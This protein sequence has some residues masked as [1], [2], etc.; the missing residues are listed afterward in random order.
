MWNLWK[1]PRG[2]F[3]IYRGWASGVLRWRRSVDCFSPK[4]RF[5]LLSTRCVHTDIHNSSCF[6]PKIMKVWFQTVIIVWSIFSAMLPQLR[7]SDVTM[8]F[9]LSAH[10]AIYYQADSPLLIL[11]EHLTLYS[12]LE[13]WTG[14]APIPPHIANEIHTRAQIS[15][16]VRMVCATARPE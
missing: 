3:A 15:R 8:S 7:K 10:S 9:G 14:L 13:A 5:T 2:K 1:V 12:K 16:K 11:W 4:L 6:S